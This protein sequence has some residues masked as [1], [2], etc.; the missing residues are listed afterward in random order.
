MSGAKKTTLM[1]VKTGE[2]RSL[3]RV[4]ERENKGRETTKRENSYIHCVWVTDYAVMF[5]IL[6]LNVIDILY[7]LPLNPL[8]R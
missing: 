2:D 6:S 1:Y 4:G 3:P 7:K 5:S 8:N